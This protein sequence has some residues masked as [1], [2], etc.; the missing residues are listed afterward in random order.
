MNRMTMR[1]AVHFQVTAN[2]DM[3][4]GDA[5][6]AQD[7]IRREVREMGLMVDEATWK[8]NKRMVSCR[9]MHT[10]RVIEEG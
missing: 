4:N 3:S 6:A 5:I 8:F 1:E 9:T 2:F 10:S 7:E